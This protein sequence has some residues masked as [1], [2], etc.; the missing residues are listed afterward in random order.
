MS[1]QPE[2]PLPPRNEF[3]HKAALA[4]AIITPLAMLLPPRKADI[5]L[6]VL[7]GTFSLCTNQLAYEY[8]GQSVYGRLGSRVGS[9]FD[10]SLPE[11]AKRTQQLL[12]EQ[13]EREAAH[14]QKQEETKN[15]VLKDIWMGGESE[16]WKER[17]AEEHNK[18]FQEGKG[19]SDII[20]EQVADV[21]S[22]NWR[23]KGKADESSSSDDSQ[24]EKKK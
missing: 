18:S 2:T 7:V 3:I 15:S 9:I 23:G 22:G 1:E 8:T 21:F 17:R 20:F 5:R 11:G 24:G 6:F 14:K 19:M 13:K 4:G 12:K 16:G 10:T